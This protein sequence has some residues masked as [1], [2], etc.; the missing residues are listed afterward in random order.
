MFQAANM[1]LSVATL[2]QRMRLEG[3]MKDMK[4]L[5]KDQGYAGITS[6]DIPNM[7]A[8][9]TTSRSFSAVILFA[10]QT[11]NTKFSLVVFV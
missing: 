6:E 4:C 7:E 9:R 8:E 10:Q 11:Q 3:M 1:K 5:G 2:F